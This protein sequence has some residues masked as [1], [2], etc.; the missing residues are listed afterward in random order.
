MYSQPHKRQKIDTSPERLDE[1]SARCQSS[2]EG[3]HD[4]NSTVL[5]SKKAER[6]NDYNRVSTTSPE[7][8]RVRNPFAKQIISPEKCAVSNSH[9]SAIRKFS[10]MRKT[11]IDSSTVVQSR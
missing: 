6:D 5:C 11:V 10:R 9:F 3:N 7:T 8:T 4:K 1:S 2:S